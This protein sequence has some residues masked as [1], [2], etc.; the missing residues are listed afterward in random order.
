MSLIYL[1]VRALLFGS[2]A[3]LIF[4]FMEPRAEETML[5]NLTFLLVVLMGIDV[6]ETKESVKAIRK[7]MFIAMRGGIDQ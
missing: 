7:A 1:I 4:G 2:I 6:L 5:T 3:A